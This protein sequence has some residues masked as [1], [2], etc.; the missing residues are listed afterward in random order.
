M[1]RSAAM[2]PSEPSPPGQGKPPPGNGLVTA[3]NPGADPNASRL[4]DR[5]FSLLQELIDDTLGIHI[6]QHKR[7]MLEGRISRRM[8]ELSLTNISDYCKLLATPA[9]AKA[10]LQPFFN[11]VTT[12]KTS[13]FRELPQLSLVSQRH[14]RNYLSQAASEH[15]PLRVWSA[16]CSS[17][18]EVWTLCMMLER[19]RRALGLNADFSVT[20]TDISTKVLKVAIGA[21]YPSTELSEVPTEYRGFLMR[22]RDPQRAL[23]RV[24]PSLREKAGFMQMNLMSQ[25]YDVSGAQDVIFLRNVLIY[26][27]RGR[28]LSIVRQVVEWLRPG[29]LLA[30]GLTESLHGSGLPL[31]NMGSSLYVKTET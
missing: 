9:T 10:E 23:I 29:G 2:R 8:R 7:T 5:E 31:T 1:T 20:G 17:G 25:R 22:S 18:Q 4:S 16:A 15:R 24:V 13:F 12:N 3:P 21:K 26:F 6:S 19:E 28:Q 30:L 27:E 11:L 14:L